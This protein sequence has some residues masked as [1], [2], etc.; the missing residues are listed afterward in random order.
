[1]ADPKSRRRR[2]CAWHGFDIGK[3][4]GQAHCASGYRSGDIEKWNA[5]SGAAALVRASFAG[6]GGGEFLAGGVVLHG[7]G[8]GFGIGENFSGGIDDG[9]AG[10]GGMAFLGGDFSESVG[11]V[12]FDAVGEQECLLREVALNLGAQRGFPGAA[13]HDIENGGGGGDHDQ[14]NGEEFEEDAVLH[15]SSI[16]LVRHFGDSKR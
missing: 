5:E 9:G 10:A 12:G 16:R 6:E 8:I 4:I 2:T 3:W 15:V 1:M 14:E 13:D 11:A 7:G